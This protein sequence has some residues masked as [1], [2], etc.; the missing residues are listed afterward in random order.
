MRRIH[1]GLLACLLVVT[2]TS[3]QQLLTLEQCRE[4][5][6]GSNKQAVIAEQTA[7]QASYD[8]KAYRANFLPKF[9][10]TG[11]YLLS[12]NSMS[13]T[14]EMPA[15]LSFIPNIPLELKINN[16]Y[17]L[18]VQAE[19]PLYMGGKL[20]AAYKMSQIG[21]QMSETNKAL[22]RTEIIA[23]TDAAYWT[24]VKVRELHLSAV[25]YKEVVSELLR[26]VDNAYKVGMKQRNDV[27]KVQVKLNE[28]ELQL[29]RAENAIKLA[30]MN[31][32]HVIGLPL[33]SPVSISES[34]PESEVSGGNNMPAADIT[35]RPEYTLL[36]QQIDLQHQQTRLTRSDF[37]PSVGVMGSYSYVN[38]LKLNGMKLFDDTGFTALFS[39]NIPLFEWGK[40]Y[41]KMKSARVQENIAKLNRL[42]AEEKMTLE[43]A[44]AL[45][46]LD[47]AQLETELTTSSLAQA[48]ENMNV[49]R[50]QYEAG[51]ET[52]ADYLEAQTVWQKAASDHINAKAS[53]QLSQTNYLKAAGR[54]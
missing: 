40:G 9:S 32:C 50:Q 6:L 5:A 33:D 14:I 30:R 38:G 18:G 24:C 54:L 11:A 49:S 47:E 48:E 22:T 10:A 20:R 42:D 21:K 17:M 12:S 29:R 19:Q 2:A 39:V 26:V 3:A 28:A 16:T 52:L 37:L 23:R 4:M 44:Q 41:N 8:V 51:M 43:V 7:E 13:E 35:L 45:N 34:F 53:L 36:T 31:L 15:E 46:A 1:I 27:L 25:K